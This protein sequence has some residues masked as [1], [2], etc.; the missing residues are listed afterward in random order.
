MKNPEQPAGPIEPRLR[1]L[2]LLDSEPAYSQ[3]ALCCQESGRYHWAQP[4]VHLDGMNVVKVDGH[5]EPMSIE[6]FLLTWTHFRENLR[7]CSSWNLQ[8]RVARED[9]EVRV[10]DVTL[11]L[12]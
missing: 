6:E 1:I 3:L 7:S 10:V 2:L 9:H 4:R 12:V 11:C 5:L 8:S